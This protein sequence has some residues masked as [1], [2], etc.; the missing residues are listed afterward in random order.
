VLHHKLLRDQEV[1]RRFAQEAAALELLEHP[2]IPRLFAHDVEGTPPY[3]AME[4]ARGGSAMA[5][6]RANGPMPPTLA[7]QVI[8]AVCD[9][10]AHAH[11]SGILHRD[12]KP[13]NFL[14]DDLGVTKLTDFGIARV[15]DATSLTAT[16]SQIGT[17][18]YM[19]PEQRADTKSVDHRA[20]VYAVA[21]SLYTLLSGR[22]SAELFVSDKDDAILAEVPPAF[23]DVLLKATRY[24]PEDRHISI[25]AFR[26]D[27]ADAVD[28]MS[29]WPAPAVPLVGTLPPL[30]DGPPDLLPEGRRFADLDRMLALL[31]DHPTFTDEAVKESPRPPLIPY[32]MKART[33]DRDVSPV[34][35]DYVDISE[36]GAL[37]RQHE[38]ELR[39]AE[40]RTA[41][42][43]APPPPKV[44]AEPEEPPHRTHVLPWILGAT[45]G[46]VI[47]GTALVGAGTFAMRDARDAEDEAAVG[48]TDALRTEVDM[49]YDLPGDRAKFET[50][51]AAYR[52]ATGSA[53][54]AAALAFVDAVD[55]AV[56]GRDVLDPEL[57]PHL[58]R[59]EAARDRYLEAKDAHRESAE[60]IPGMFA[61]RTGF[62]PQPD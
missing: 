51:Y 3:M 60:R 34:V 10:L 58:R 20:D 55:A 50:L 37:R 56:Q 44:V 1:R 24:D 19:A 61:V 62:A 5:W 48:L 7:A 42:V 36:V 46:L 14:L 49:V 22:A 17:F 39:E 29:P 25:E 43:S 18:S 4:L 27:L 26:E 6:V 30:P 41:P 23:R 8:L 21:A 28:R 45:S 12:V 13:H 31:E 9:A 54:V 52:D 2:H 40:R 32:I 38:S 11:A 33:P 15:A 35:P 59:L 53:R 16:G 57:E 47:L